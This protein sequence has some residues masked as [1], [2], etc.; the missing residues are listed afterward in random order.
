MKTKVTSAKREGGKIQVS[1]EALKDGKQ[2][3][4]SALAKLRSHWVP[5]T[6]LLTQLEWY[7][8]IFK[9]VA[10]VNSRDVIFFSPVVPKWHMLVPEIQQAKKS[11]QST[12][13]GVLVPKAGTHFNYVANTV[14]EVIDAVCKGTLI[15]RVHSQWTIELAIVTSQTNEYHCYLW[16]L[17]KGHTVGSWWCDDEGISPRFQNSVKILDLEFDDVIQWNSIWCPS[18]SVSKGDSILWIN[19]LMLYEMQGVWWSGTN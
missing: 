1:T 11:W 5:F 12:K 15:L 16:S 6:T 18:W 4:V 9:I 13:F 10:I 3:E 8:P 7:V 19:H 17:W 2:Q 14:T